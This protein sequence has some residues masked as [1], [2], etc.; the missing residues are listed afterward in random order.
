VQVKYKKHQKGDFE[1]E[2]C[3][4]NIDSTRGKMYRFKIETS[5]NLELKI[6]QVKAGSMR[7]KPLTIAT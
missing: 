5:Q 3:P 6:F 4:K 7:P 1:R 2:I